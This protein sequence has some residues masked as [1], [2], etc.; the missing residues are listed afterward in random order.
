[1]PRKKNKDVIDWGML[2]TRVIAGEYNNAPEQIMTDLDDLH[3]RV[4]LGVQ[5]EKMGREGIETVLEMVP[6]LE[7]KIIQA[8]D[9]IAQHIITKAESETSYEQLEINFVEVF[10]NA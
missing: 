5:Q 8:K 9:K 10:E 1:M 6:E 3:Q 2:A 4:K 7:L